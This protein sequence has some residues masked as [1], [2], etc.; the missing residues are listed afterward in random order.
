MLASRASATRR[1]E[2]RLLPQGLRPLLASDSVNLALER[3]GACSTPIK[4]AK[5]LS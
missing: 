2:A 1:A 3:L 4:F 5:C